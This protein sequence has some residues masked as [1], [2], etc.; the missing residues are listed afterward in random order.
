MRD[1][2]RPVILVVDPE[3][4]ASHTVEELVARYSRDYSIVADP[5]VAAASQRLRTL[6]ET[7]NDIALVLADRA[8]NGAPLLDEARALHPHA[9]RGLLLNWNESRTHREEVAVSFARRQAECF[10][11][12]PSGTPDERF[13]RSIT[14]LLDEW[15]R[16]RG[17]RSTAIRVV[18]AEGTAR[19]HEIRDL[20]QR[21]DMPF[22]FHAA[23]SE[24]GAAILDVAG[25]NPGVA[26]VVVVENGRV[27]VDP[28]NIEVADALGA[29]TRPGSGIYDLVIVGG[30][31]AGLSAAVSAESEGLRTALIE[32][33]AMG[34]Q[35]G[36]SSMIRNYLGFP[37]ASAVPSW[38]RAPLSKPS[39]LEP[40]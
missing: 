19:V 40:R 24:A 13:H 12:K 33:T 16:I 6:A 32:P 38:R 34:G 36:T 18:G 30:G 3:A 22:D 29:R 26:P 5:N 35:A 27:L 14:E 2:A 8:S 11:A 7:A 28:S 23:D 9:R 1:S 37:R 17:P 15:W 39:C 21:H 4:G 10:V 31:P 25:V 20:L